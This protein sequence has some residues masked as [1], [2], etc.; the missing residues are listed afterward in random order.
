M[1]TELSFLLD[2]LL[3][4]KLPAKTKTAVSERIKEVEIALNSRVPAPAVG[5]VAPSHMP[6]RINT[7]VPQAASMQAIIDRNPDLVASIPEQTPTPTI[8]SPTSGLPM[9]VVHIAQTPA[10]AAALASRN[11]AMANAGKIE[12][13]RTSPRKY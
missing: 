2:L 5:N 1:V 7:G 4:H 13:G 11:A 9:P 10:T 8:P 3:S 12:P 6:M